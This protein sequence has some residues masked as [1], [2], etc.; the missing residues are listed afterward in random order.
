[1]NKKD[2]QILFVDD[3]DRILNSYKEF[4]EKEMNSTFVNNPTDAIKMLKNNKYQILVTDYNLKSDKFGTDIID[5]AMKQNNNIKCLLVSG[6][7]DLPLAKDMNKIGVKIFDKLTD[8]FVL[9][10][11]I[12]NCY[13]DYMQYQEILRNSVTGAMMNQYMHDTAN[14]I[15]AISLGVGMSIKTLPDS[16]DMKPIKDRLARAENTAKNF[17]EASKLFKSQVS[18][19]NE[20]ELSKLS[21]LNFAEN[22]RV[23][24]EAI[25]INNGFEYIE[26]IKDLDSNDLILV[27]SIFLTHVLNN[28][29]TNSVH[30]NKNAPHKW[31][32][33]IYSKD[34]EGRLNI[35]V[36]D[37]GKPLSKEIQDKLFKEQF[38]TK[39][40]EGTGM[41]LSYCKNH[42]ESFMGTICY[43]K[44]NESNC[45]FKIV[46]KIQAAEGLKS[47][48]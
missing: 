7:L 34:F 1:M 24:I 31:V 4:F 14:S 8:N 36:V 18:G 15:Q 5:F 40:S 37:C 39:G 44:W 32:K 35:E 6:Q 22:C 42:I 11:E 30:A 23:E 21:V 25:C 47:A 13:K 26:E 48:A 29:V 20:I 17:M 2:I 10:E 27:Q 12:L 33:V 3:E 43:D 41:G 16:E 28:L 19:M 45:S 9:E 38:T 46:L